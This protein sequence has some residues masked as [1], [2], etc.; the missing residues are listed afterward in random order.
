M[1]KK[2]KY[3]LYKKNKQHGGVYFFRIFPREK[4]LYDKN[5]LQFSFP[6]YFPRMLLFNVNRV[7]NGLLYSDASKFYQLEFIKYP[8][9]TLDK[10]DVLIFQQEAI[11]EL[12]N[13]IKRESVGH[14]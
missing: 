4:F 10:I 5:D 13:D 7:R 2:L 3:F 8:E 1:N 6:G 14:K 11:E 12:Y 9:V